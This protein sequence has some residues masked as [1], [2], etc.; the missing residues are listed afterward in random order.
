[1]TRAYW[2][3]DDGLRVQFGVG[4]KPYESS[5]AAV[6]EC[7]L[8]SMKKAIVFDFDYTALPTRQS[9]NAQNGFI[10]AG[11]IVT[12]AYIFV[13]QAWT[14]LTDLTAGFV[15]TDGTTAIDIDG[16]LSATLGAQA[17]LTAGLIARCDGAL[18]PFQKV[19]GG[20]GDPA[21]D[22]LIPA[23]VQLAYDAYFE[24]YANGTATAG[25]ARIVIEYIEPYTAVI[26]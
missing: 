4:K 15:R 10:P 23:Q 11:S 19:A 2:N 18:V 16:I 13:D 8:A 25:S 5:G 1:M 14:G 21:N 20:A 24:A 22:P 9:G 26:R 7:G 12:D 3:N 17:N 6:A